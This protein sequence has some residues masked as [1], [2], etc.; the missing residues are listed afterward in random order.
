[1]PD[2]IDRVGSLA[3]DRVAG[4]T[5]DTLMKSDPIWAQLRG[6][7]SALQALVIAQRAQYNALLA[8]LDLDAGVTDV[9]YASTVGVSTTTYPS[10]AL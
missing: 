2:A 1:M 7:I 8:K 3:A 6:E 10:P 5:N 9:D 4:L